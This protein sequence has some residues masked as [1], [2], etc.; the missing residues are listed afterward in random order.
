M[1][2]KI[3]TDILDN[4][5]IEK[6]SE[7]LK[8]NLVSVIAYGWRITDPEKAL[9]SDCQ[10][11]IVTK[12]WSELDL[13][14]ARSTLQWWTKEKFPLPALFTH[15][16]FLE[17]LDVFPVEFLHMKQAYRV[18]YG[19]DIVADQH[20]S[21]SNLRSQIEY[22]LRGKLLRL[23]SL[24]IPASISTNELINLMTQSVISFIRCIRPI[25]ILFGEDNYVLRNAAI[26]SAGRCLSIDTSILTTILELRGEPEKRKHLSDKAAKQLFS[27]YLECLERI[28]NA[29]NNI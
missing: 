19:A 28:I 7:H 5:L 6:L 9:R 15:K 21:K 1:E 10:L 11:M 23:R 4:K 25:P 3:T 16:E 17:S 22:E 13:L 24:Y 20:I 14:N 12:S 26:S 29:I 27:E 8:D 2:L 18:V